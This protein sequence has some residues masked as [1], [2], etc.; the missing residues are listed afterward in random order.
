MS[1]V[2]RYGREHVINITPPAF[3][4]TDAKE[5]ERYSFA[6]SP[7]QLSQELVWKESN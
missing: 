7:F 1:Q 3:T 5:K 2:D 4:T 6:S